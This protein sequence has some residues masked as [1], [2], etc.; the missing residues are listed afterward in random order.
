MVVQPTLLRLYYLLRLTYPIVVLPFLLMCSYLGFFY[1][2][3]GIPRPET[4]LSQCL[5]C[6]DSP[7]TSE[8][9]LTSRQPC[10]INNSAIAFFPF[11][12]PSFS[13]IPAR[14]DAAINKNCPLDTPSATNRRDEM[15]KGC[16]TGGMAQKAKSKKK[17]KA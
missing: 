13:S 6:C 14:S 11:F 8:V 2:A 4:S 9:N 3:K 5:T 16:R 1:I 10:L 12:H 7:L 15:E 17:K